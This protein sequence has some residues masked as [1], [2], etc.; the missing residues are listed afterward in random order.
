MRCATVSVCTLDGALAAQAGAKLDVQSLD[1]LT[2]LHL[3]AMG[4]WTTL[5]ARLLEAGADAALVDC[6]GCAPL[7]RAVRL[8]DPDLF[9]ALFPASSSCLD[10]LDTKGGCK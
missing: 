3:A 10:T 5:V 2:P 4:R 6:E 7:H 9:N 8:A 1:G